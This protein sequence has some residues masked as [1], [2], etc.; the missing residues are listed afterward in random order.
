MSITF[1]TTGLAVLVSWISSISGRSFNEIEMADLTDMIKKSVDVTVTP[2]NTSPSTGPTLYPTAG[3]DLADILKSMFENMTHG[4]KID[5]IKKY[6]LLTGARLAEAK[7]AVEI[8]MN[9]LNSEW[10]KGYKAGS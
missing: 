2:E 10:E 6:R 8:V 1:K 4:Q 7:T 9:A 5:A 3:L